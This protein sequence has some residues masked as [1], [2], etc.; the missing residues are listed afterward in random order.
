MRHDYVF[1]GTA[2]RIRPMDVSDAAF[3]V[4]L[5]TDLRLGRF[6][7]PTSARVEDQIAWLE[8]YFERPGDFYFLIE[9]KT[10]G[11]PHGAIALYDE[12]AGQ[13]A[14]WGRWIL[15]PNSLAAA[16]SALLIYRFAF[17]QRGLERVYCRTV[18]A[19]QPVVNFHTSAGLEMVGQLEDHFGPGQPSTEQQATRQNWPEIERRLTSYAERSARLL[20]RSGTT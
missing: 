9:Q 8:R 19:N 6:L 7:N 5:R 17:F 16:E 4:G 10:N 11:E 12:I 18:A 20:A 13:Q 3:V 14:E 1:E 2:F 15:R